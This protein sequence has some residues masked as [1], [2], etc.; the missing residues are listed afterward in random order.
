MQGTLGALLFVLSMTA[1]PEAYAEEP[2]VQGLKLGMTVETAKAAVGNV[3]FSEIAA[4][5][6]TVTKVLMA[7]RSAS[8]GF[9]IVTIGEK[10]VFVQYE[11][12]FSASDA[13]TVAD[14]TAA[15]VSKYGTAS[16]AQTYIYDQEGRLERTDAAGC[17]RKLDLSGT[18]T[19]PSGNIYLKYPQKWSS[20][21]FSGLRIQV[22]NG[23]SGLVDDYKATLWNE[24]PGAV[25]VQDKANEARRASEA[26]RA[27]PSNRPVPPL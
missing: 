9:V 17:A 12:I 22:R 4:D 15:V 26:K 19:V 3:T 5:A 11:R 1:S 14:L 13:P 16:V 10:L 7:L 24:E 6:G 20:G 2:S 23:T 27:A 25:L 18:L 8:E 21:C